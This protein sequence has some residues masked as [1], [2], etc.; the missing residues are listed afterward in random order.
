V[1]TIARA[2]VVASC[3]AALATGTVPIAGR[4]RETGTI[5][6]SQL[7]AFR[8]GVD[9]VQLDVS[10]LDKDRRPVRGLTAADFTVL[11]GDRSR[12]IVAFSAVEL[13]PPTPARP[14]T[15][16][17]ADS[18]AVPPDV[19]RNDLPDGRLVVILID[20]F[21]ERAMAP[22]RVTMADPPG[23]AA[24]RRIAFGVVDSLAAGDLAAV[25]HAVYGVP[26][27]FTTDRA[28]LKRAIESTAMG[29][30]KR[31]DGEEWGSCECGVCRVE[32]ITRV[33]AALRN[34][35]QRRKTV[36]YVGERLRLP[37][38]EG[39]CNAYLEPATKQMVHAAQLA[40]VTVHTL[41]PN[42]LETTNVHAGDDFQSGTPVSAGATSQ[43]KAN[44]AFLIERQQSLQAVA[45]W[46][47]GRAIMNTNAPEESVRP[48]LDESSAYY[49]LAFET[50]DT[51]RDG[52]FHPVTVKVNRPGVQ[53]RTRK[54]YYT[55]PIAQI[56]DSRASLE[57]VSLGLL[58]ERGLP[59]SVTAAAFR[60]AD[61]AA[62]VV[63]TTGVRAGTLGPRTVASRAAAAPP[64]FEPIEIR[65]SAFREGTKATEWQRQRLAVALPDAAPGQLRYESISTLILKPGSYELRVAA[66]HERAAELGSVHTFVEVPDFEN[67]ALTLSGLVLLDARAPTV[68]PPEA[69]GGILDTGPTTR[70]DF[71]V[72]DDVSALVRVYQPTGGPPAA[73]AVSFRILDGTLREVALVERTLAAGQFQSGAAD[74][75]FRLPFH[76]LPPG[77][78]V[79]RVDATAG[80]RSSRSD[81]RFTVR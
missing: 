10:V 64:Q 77:L 46:T 47:G 4:Q 27:N 42:S 36:F 71:T 44:R 7:P 52:R 63:V 79:L 60:G 67:G 12:P 65:T 11:E 32:A 73:A 39:R 15:D 53:V 72:A 69:L 26:Q 40:N 3:L 28:R 9:A 61:G 19:A 51:K 29:T 33:A 24:M 6:I 37:P 34:E 16:A 38:V 22:G 23:V 31:R 70:R 58:P 75:R 41:D 8:T 57:T 49:L 13:P 76:T 2:S 66:H 68:T 54:G 45:D 43:E 35:P 48:I 5:P 80:A 81:V 18:S 30:L 50:T 21:M 25:G 78:Y 74:A 59:L 20:P 55:E 62:T 56:S 14:P 17:A 1:N